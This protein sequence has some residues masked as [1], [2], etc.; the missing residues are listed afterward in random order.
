MCTRGKARWTGLYELT[1]PKEEKPG[2]CDL[3]NNE[4]SAKPPG[5]EKKAGT[6][7]KELQK[8]GGGIKTFIGGIFHGQTPNERVSA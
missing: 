3:R 8:G 6:S 7:A 2:V 1:P 4:L 5:R